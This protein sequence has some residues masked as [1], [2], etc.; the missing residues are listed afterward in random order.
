[1]MFFVD[2]KMRATYD[3]GSAQCDLL[4]VLAILALGLSRCDTL[5]QLLDLCL[6]LLDRGA[7]AFRLD[8]VSLVLL[9]ELGLHL[10]DD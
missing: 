2:I 4:V 8:L 1:M 5:I 10:R 6:E 7:F 9:L 3:L